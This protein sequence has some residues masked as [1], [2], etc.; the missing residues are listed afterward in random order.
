MKKITIEVV[1]SFFATYVSEVW[2]GLLSDQNE[3]SAMQQERCSWEQETCTLT[4]DSQLG[5]CH[6]REINCL[7]A[8][9]LFVLDVFL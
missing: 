5:S 7:R 9:D 4:T 8:R 6:V 2:D 3:S 1:V